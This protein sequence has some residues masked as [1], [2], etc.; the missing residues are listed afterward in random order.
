MNGETPD[1][2]IQLRSHLRATFTGIV[3]EADTGTVEVRESNFLSRA[4]AAYAVQKLTG[5]SIQ[6]AAAAVVDGKGDGG[7]D[8]IFHDKQT[9]TLWAIQS[10]FATKGQ[11]L[12]DG[13]EKFRNGLEALLMGKLDYFSTNPNWKNFIPVF[14]QLLSDSQPLQ[15]RAVFVYSSILIL[16]DYQLDPFEKLKSRF[17]H[18]DDYFCYSSYNLSSII[19]WLTGADQPIEVP[20]VKLT[21]YTPGWVRSGYETIYGMVKLADLAAL[22]TQYGTQ[23]VAANIRAYKGS[24]DVN[25]GILVTL[26]DEP[27]AFVYLNNGLTAY[28][29]NL[30]VAHR[31]RD[32]HEAKRITAKRF[33]I[34]NGAQT[35]GTIAHYFAQFPSPEPEGY[36]FLK[37]ISLERCEYELEFAQKLT[38][39]TNYQNQI[40]PRH[41]IAQDAY[42]QE[43]ARMLQ[44]S[45]IGYHYRDDIT[46][47]PSDATNFTLAEATTALTCLIQEKECDLLTRIVTDLDSLWS[48][49]ILYP[50]KAYSTRYHRIFQPERPAREVW[51]AVQVQKVVLQTLDA[52]AKKHMGIQRQFYQ[53]T[54]WLLLNLI[55]NRLVLPE[56]EAM[57]LA[58]DEIEAIRMQLSASAELLWEVCQKEKIIEP[59][60]EADN[61]E[62]FKLSRPFEDLFSQADVCAVLRKEM[63]ISLYNHNLPDA[64]V[65]GYSK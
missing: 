50:D 10:K 60:G 40:G 34:V 41:F 44:L 63:L 3:P 15:I 9:D 42:Q 46:V 57:L 54:R 32:N 56:R 12:P 6:A 49:E 13:L 28:C 62:V 65:D 16:D 29:D 18:N 30:K 8:A 43:L 17:T 33:S 27:E 1:G 2:L 48:L 19:D 21:L 36:V 5:C 14:D 4:L 59:C 61:G 23:L 7:I 45:G 53:H 31:D 24:T 47:P 58:L 11:G 55:F 35:L 22:Y 52:E 51:R 64:S 38:R 20:E 25:E 26:R 39:T 37:L